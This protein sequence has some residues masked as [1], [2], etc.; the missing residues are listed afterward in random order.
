MSSAVEL[1]FCKKCLLTFYQPFGLYGKQT[2]SFSDKTPGIS[3]KIFIR[4]SFQ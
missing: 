2:S 4:S 1:P 3:A